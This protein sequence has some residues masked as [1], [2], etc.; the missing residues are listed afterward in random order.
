M[1]RSDVRQ[2]NVPGRPQAGPGIQDTQKPPS[3]APVNTQPEP[4]RAGLREAAPP[5]NCHNC[6][7]KLSAVELKMGRCLTCGKLVA[8]EAADGA[9]TGEGSAVPQKFEIRI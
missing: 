3:P 8:A 2:L 4:R 7:A 1:S 5:A 6:K 9:A